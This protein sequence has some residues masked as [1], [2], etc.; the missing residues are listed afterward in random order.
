M[1]EGCEL[2]WALT[3]RREAAFLVQIADR[4]DLVLEPIDTFQ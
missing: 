3:D 4:C 2:I 1:I